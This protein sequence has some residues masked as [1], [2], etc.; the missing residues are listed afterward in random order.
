MPFADDFDEFCEVVL[1]GW[2]GD[3][4]CEAGFLGEFAFLFLFEMEPEAESGRDGE[5]ERESDEESGGEEGIA[6][7]HGF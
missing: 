3:G 5:P 1:E 4:F 7:A 2:D 6:A